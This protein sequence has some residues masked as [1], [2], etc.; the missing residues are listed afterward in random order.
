M[1]DSTKQELRRRIQERVEED[2]LECPSCSFSEFEIEV[3]G[4]GMEREE[5][6][7][8]AVCESCGARLNIR[9]TQEDLD[10]I[11]DDDE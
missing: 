4:V 10:E 5:P 6:R 9:V 3:W 2:E 11:R 8:A 7:S 1:S